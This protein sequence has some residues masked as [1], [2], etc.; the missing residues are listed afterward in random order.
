MLALA[1]LAVSAPQPPGSTFKIITLSGA[2]AAGIATPSTSF[3]VRTSA[4]LSGVKL[5]NAGGESCGGTLTQAFIDSCNSVFAPLGAKLGAT[6]LV[7][8]G[9]GVRLQRAPARPRRQGEHDPAGRAS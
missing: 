8:D 6:R 9:R 4:T 2:L 5:R 3:P 1:G 7:R